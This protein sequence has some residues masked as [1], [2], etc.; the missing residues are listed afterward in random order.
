MIGRYFLL[1][2][3]RLSLVGCILCSATQL[4][5]LS[6]C[7]QGGCAQADCDDGLSLIVVSKSGGSFSPGT[8]SLEITADDMTSTWLCEVT[9]QP[10]TSHCTHTSADIGELI[11]AS[12]NGVDSFRWQTS[13]LP[14]ELTVFVSRDGVL[15]SNVT[16]HPS[17]RE[18]APNGEACDPIC[19]AAS[20][21]LEV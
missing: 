20:E 1:N 8:Y 13:A 4:P 16:I 6:G 19:Q 15:L 7:S 11:M 21:K 2:G 18:I 12:G 10:N 5:A 17:Y 14:A 3:K 9:D